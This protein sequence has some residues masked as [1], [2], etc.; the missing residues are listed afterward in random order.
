VYGSL[1]DIGYNEGSNLFVLYYDWRRS[2]F[3]SATMLESLIKTHPELKDKDFDILAHSMGDLVAKIYISRHPNDNHVIRLISLAVPWRGSM[4]SLAEMAQGWGGFEN[5]VAGGLSTVRHV[6]F[7]FPSVFELMPSYDNCCRIGDPDKG[8]AKKFPQFDP[9]DPTLWV[10]GDWLPSE[11]RSGG[12]LNHVLE[13]LKSAAAVRAVVSQPLPSTVDEIRFA[14]GAF[15]T[16]LY[17]YVDPVNRSWAHWKFHAASGDGTVPL[18]SAADNK[19]GSSLVAFVDHA[20]IFDD[21]WVAAELDR[22]LNKNSGPPP[23]KES[24]LGVTTCNPSRFVNVSIVDASL[25]RV[26]V[27]IGESVSLSLSLTSVEP[28]SKNCLHPQ[29]T[30]VGSNISNTVELHELT[31]KED[32][33]KRTAHFTASILAKSPGAYSLRLTMP[34]FGGS[35]TTD[36][37]A[38]DLPAK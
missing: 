29:I 31:S 15:S 36:F 16:R 12:A 13:N 8:D 24:H 25:D 37:I 28:L 21:R 4:N 9:T 3:D 27:S 10:Q 32:L 34:G 19:V 33:E 30:A 5:Y 2:N 6:I 23:V 18:W 35:Y 17:L 26:V 22:M 1:S 7:S 11:Y 38:L 20:T 14:S